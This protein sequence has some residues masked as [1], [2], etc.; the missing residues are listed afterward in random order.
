MKKNLILLFII[1][2]AGLSA[3]DF[4]LQIGI[5]EGC[6]VANPLGNTYN[7]TYLELE[8]LANTGCLELYYE[9]NVYDI[10]GARDIRRDSAQP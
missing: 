3:S 4:W 5:D 1:L 10:L 7:L 6:G 8:G 2:A 9:L